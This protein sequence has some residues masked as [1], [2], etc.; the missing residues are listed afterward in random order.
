MHGFRAAGIR[1]SILLGTQYVLLM[2]I[3]FNRAGPAKMEQALELMKEFYAVEHLKYDETIARKGLEAL[4]AGPQ[5]GYF[6][7]METEGQVGGYIVVTFGFSLEFH[8]RDALVDELYV[9]EEFR[10]RGFGKAA[11]GFAEA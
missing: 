1:S 2:E 5:F 3:K 10:G 4:F 11:L 6:H 8:G 9:R 7:F